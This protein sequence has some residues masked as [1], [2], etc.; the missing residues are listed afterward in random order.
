MIVNY[1]AGK[2]RCYINLKNIISEKNIKLN[3]IDLKAFCDS[4]YNFLK[5]EL[6]KILFENC[7]DDF[8]QKIGN[9]LICDDNSAINLAYLKHKETKE[10]IKVADCR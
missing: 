1:N 5:I 6:F 3:D 7:K 10:D 8:L 4:F 9:I 2:N